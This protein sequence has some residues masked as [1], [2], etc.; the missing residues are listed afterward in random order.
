M[1]DIMATP[2]EP[3]FSLRTTYTMDKFH[4]HTIRPIPSTAADSPTK[5]YTLLYSLTT[6]RS[7]RCLD[8]LRVFIDTQCPANSKLMF[9]ASYGLPDGINIRV[10]RDSRIIE[11][12]TPT[13]CW[14][15]GPSY[16]AGILLSALGS[17]SQPT[18]PSAS[19][20]GDRQHKLTFTDALRVSGERRACAALSVS[21]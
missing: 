10:A 18:V 13:A 9:E 7:L 8:H 15:T 14:G 1:V 6:Q 12:G 16:P 19:S 21:F 2:V 4:L 5:V 11:N 3:S 20:P 17:T